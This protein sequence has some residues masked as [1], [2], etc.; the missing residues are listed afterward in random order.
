MF[1]AISGHPPKSPVVSV[2][3][4]HIF[5]RRLL[6]QH[7][8][9]NNGLCPVTS[10]PLSLE[11]DT[12]PVKAYDAVKP[13]AVP[14][15]SIPG[16]LGIFQSEWDSLMA[17]TFTL[18]KHLYE[19]RQELAQALYRQD[20]ACR[21]IARV[22]AERDDLQ[23]AVT[24]LRGQ[25]AAAHSGAAQGAS[26]RPSSAAAST[27]S[28]STTSA[29]PPSSAVVV[30]AACDPAH[31]PPT[32]VSGL[33][34]A[35]AALQADR[36]ARKKNKPK[37]LPKAAG[38]G[39]LA[40]S[41]SR[42]LHKVRPPGVTCLAAHPRVFSGSPSDAGPAAGAFSRLL[43]TGGADGEARLFDLET[44]KALAPFRG[45]KGAVT[46]AAFHP[47]RDEAYTAGADGT[48][49][50]W[51]PCAAEGGGGEAGRTGA[52][53]RKSPR[54]RKRSRSSSKSPRASSPRYE[55][56]HVD[57]A[58]HAGALRC[59]AVHPG[60]DLLL[61]GSDDGTFAVHDIAGRAPLMRMRRAG[62]PDGSSSGVSAVAWHPDGTLFAVAL[63]DGSAA[64]YNL[65]AMDK[66]GRAGGSSGGESSALHDAA[67]VFDLGAARGGLRSLDFS[68]NGYHVA[69]ADAAGRV[70]LWDLRAQALA[71]AG[72]A[73]APA[74]EWS[75]A[76]RTEG[77]GSS[78][79]VARF[80]WTGTYLAVGS[81]SGQVAVLHVKKWVQVALLEAHE[82]AVTGLAWCANDARRLC[83]VSADRTL[84]VYTIE[85]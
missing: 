73:F 64:L 11:D 34:E 2:K 53:P 35:S 74:R 15:A 36:K 38:M 33:V 52:S 30:T 46:A 66:G 72:S 61:A 81:A 77:G 68:E 16:M 40:P 13:R 4:G 78:G 3:S 51:R 17:E 39:A 80:D 9:S 31:F 60:G 41:M 18:K 19:T 76:A 7:L 14:A 79:A 44:G 67:I 26:A 12:V 10:Q 49:R 50:F 69:G 43:L 27:A 24:A 23:A 48:L 21:V 22:T 58:T 65:R 82:G 47:S 71:T 32:L 63:E 37:T 25:L 84:K 45:H 8:S 56:F 59:L 42:T 6:E 85:G 29:A 54:K 75:P 1:C 70:C 55:A 5:E 28:A 62:R 20:A 57:E 83:S